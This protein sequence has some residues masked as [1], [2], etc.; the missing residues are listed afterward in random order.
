[1]KEVD[2]K[3]ADDLVWTAANRMIGGMMSFDHGARAIIVMGVSASGKSV[4]GMR[5]A[6]TIGACFVEGDDLH[7]PENIA[8]MVGGSP[9]S[10]DDRWPWLDKVHGK[11]IGCLEAERSVV[12][13]CSALRRSY[14]DRLRKG[15]ACR[16]QFVF[17]DGPR[18]LL[19]KR[20]ARRSTHFMPAS[21]LAS[22]LATLERPLDENDVIVVSIDQSVDAI[23]EDAM[24]GL[25]RHGK[26]NP[27]ERPSH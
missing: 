5:L 21:L 2:A 4:V 20:I 3:E 18:E 7:P 17:L 9:L 15:L 26:A 25:E 1:M 14:R 10:D 23:V 8:K 19:E 11:I 27:A 12:V 24:K 6:R 16:L 22:Q 13:S